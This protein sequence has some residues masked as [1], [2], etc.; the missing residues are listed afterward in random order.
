MKVILIS[1]GTRGDMEPF[2]AIG[3][4]LK[5]KGHQVTCA[6]PEQFRE[7]AEEADLEY[8][9]LGKMFI[10]LLESDAGMNAM[11]GS[12]GLRKFAATIKLAQNQTEANQELVR[13]QY[14][15]VKKH[16][17]DRIIYNGKAVYPILWG[18][19]NQ[20]KNILISPLPYMHYVKDHAHI[21]FN[22][23]L[24]P[25][26][27]KWT[28][29]LAELGLIMTAQIA[30]KWIN[31][32]EKYSRKQIK[33]ALHSNK[34]IYAIS[35][36]LFSRPE[37]WG[38]N[39]QVLGF[40]ERKKKTHWQPEKVLEDFL[41]RHK[42]C[43]ILLISFGSM[44]NP[45]PAEK[46]R[47]ILDILERNQIPAIINTAA[48]GLIKPDQYDL[49]LLHFVNRIP[50][51]WILPRMYGVIHHGGA[52]TTHLGLKYGCATLI[53]PHIIDQFVWDKINAKI[54]SGPRGIRIDQINTKNLGNRIL[55]LA[56]NPNY[57][58]KAERV[59][60]QMGKED[61]RDQIYQSLIGEDGL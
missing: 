28:Y 7:L 52:G 19:K 12:S 58:N 47:V 34:A 50:Y 32:G 37:N 17:P 16:N 6:F 57:K 3:E 43:R 42:E 14:E 39:L 18:I 40:H 8:A 49:E 22:A 36:S 48:G 5:E 9:S 13:N 45:D 55:E 41:E 20:G 11:G 24:G 61:Y 60:N 38:A 1:V 54:G 27:N 44:I 10:E 33:T 21:G 51:D 29:S 53:I 31:E 46:T 23:N 2:L 59:A 25:I 30:A 35:P 26:M 15:I 56:N 4:I